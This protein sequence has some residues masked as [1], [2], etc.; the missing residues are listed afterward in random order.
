MRLPLVLLLAGPLLP[1]ATY[2][3]TVAGLGGEPEYE[4]RFAA[5]AQEIDK[6][7]RAGNPDAKVQTLS[8]PQ[9]TKAQLQSALAAI[10]KE[11]KPSDALVLMLIGHGSFDG[12]DYK[13]NLPGPDLTAVELAA[14]L[15]RIPAS[16]QLVVNM[17]SASGG[18]RAVLEKP[19][20]AIITATKSGSEKNAT[21]FA[22]Y[23]VEALRDPAA[24]TDKN[25][26]VSALEAFVY[27][28]QKTSQFYETQKRLA[29]EHP[30]LEDTGQSDGTRKPS[31]ENG[32]GRI[33]SQIA[34]LHL[35]AT[36]AIANTPEKKVLLARREEL[37][38]QIDTLKYEKAA[39]PPEEYKKQLQILLLELAKTQAELDK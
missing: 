16:H 34:L 33:A 5:Q 27:A 14:L 19:N 7:I 1:G 12:V 39:T 18:S 3:V 37:E 35:G 25:E 23:W 20:R 38:Q 21:I 31:P 8:G 29:T 2:Y 26:T 4:Q 15:D 9:A 17:T 24:D 11:A 6:L 13:I 22:R 28:E 10:A 36:Q 30:M 32:E